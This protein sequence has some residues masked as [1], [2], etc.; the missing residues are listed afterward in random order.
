MKHW[1]LIAYDVRE[2]KR[3]RRV[4]GYLRKQALALQKSVFAIE[5][6]PRHLEEVLEKV[7]ERAD[8]R[9]DDIRLY[10]IPGPS[11]MWAAGKQAGA[12]VG[13]HSGEAEAR[14]GSIV[15]RLFKGLFGREAA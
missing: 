11:A 2:P 6:D 10:A 8:A 14:K 9:E 15:K 3:L 5:T 13:L 12:L 4:H 7:R 1:Y